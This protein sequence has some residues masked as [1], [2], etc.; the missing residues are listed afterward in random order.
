[1]G[2]PWKKLGCRDNDHVNGGSHH[3][4]GYQ[5]IAGRS[6]TVEIGQLAKEPRREKRERLLHSP[7]A[8]QIVL[9]I[10]S[11]LHNGVALVPQFAQLM[12]PTGANLAL[13]RGFEL[14]EASSSGDSG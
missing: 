6:R 1:M 12:A 9:P 7:Q 2:R 11:R 5:V 8:L 4:V 13:K 3:I 14:F 10:S